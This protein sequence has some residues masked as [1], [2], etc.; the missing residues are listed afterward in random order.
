MLDWVLLEIFECG[1][2]VVLGILGCGKL[3]LFNVMVGFLLFFEGS[4]IFDGRLVFGF[5][6]E[7]GVVF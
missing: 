4:I 3:I 6:V 7:C 2:V 5:G 1:F